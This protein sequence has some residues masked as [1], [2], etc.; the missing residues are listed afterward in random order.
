MVT[1]EINDI[2]VIIDKHIKI[3][4]VGG[5]SKLDKEVEYDLLQEAIDALIRR[6]D[7]YSYNNDK[8]NLRRVRRVLLDVKEK[9]LI[10]AIK[11][12]WD[13][14]IENLYQKITDMHLWF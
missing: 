6:Y 3:L 5:L 7:L 11:N 10:Y 1:N 9:L 13:K 4:S 8:K 14:I 2:H 12:P